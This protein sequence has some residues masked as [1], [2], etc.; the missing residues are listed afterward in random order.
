MHLFT[1]CSKTSYAMVKSC[2]AL[3]RSKK[4]KK[5]DLS[6]GVNENLKVSGIGLSRLRKLLALAFAS[7]TEP[8]SW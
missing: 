6:L 4:V 8:I 7:S 2:E 1:N 5:G 3:I